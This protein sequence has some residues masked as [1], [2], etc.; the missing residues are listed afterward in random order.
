M[1]FSWIK[2]LIS[3]LIIICLFGIGIVGYYTFTHTLPPITGSICFIVA[4]ALFICFVVLLRRHSL[5][6]SNPRFLWVFLS[7]LGILLVCTFAGIQPLAEFKDRLFNSI[8]T[9]IQQYSTSSSET[10]SQPLPTELSNIVK[11]PL[12]PYG[13]YISMTA[14]FPSLFALNSDGTCETNNGFSISKD[15]Y[16]IS[17]DYITVYDPLTNKATQIKYQYIDKVKCLYLYI[18]GLNIRGLNS[19]GLNKNEPAAYYRQ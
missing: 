7:V 18:G 19:G 14:G 4:V 1:K 17:S 2:L 3:I 13:K 5:R 15:T 8:S 11:Q 9:G 10:T 16:T 6:Y 12:I